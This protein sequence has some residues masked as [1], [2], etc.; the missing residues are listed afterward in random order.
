M[1]NIKFSLIYNRK[2]Q[3]NQDGSALIQIK[4]YLKGKN[5]YF[6]SEIYV[7]PHQWD[8]RNKK[9]KR[10]P[11]QYP[12]N[13]K[14]FE[15]LE[16]LENRAMTLHSKQDGFINLEQLKDD[17]HS[18]EYNSFTQFF[19]IEMRNEQ[20]SK[21]TRKTYVTTFR[22]IK[23]FRKSIHFKELNFELI[24]TFDA[25]L[26]ESGL[27]QNTIAK[28][29]K[30]VK[31]FINLAIKMNLMDYSDNPYRKF[32]IKKE[33]TER[34]FL[35]ESEIQSLEALNLES[36]SSE[37]EPIRDMFLFSCYTGLRY[38][39]VSRLCLNHLTKNSKGYLL[40]MT[41]QKTGKKIELPLYALFRVKDE[42]QSKPERIIEKQIEYHELIL[43]KN[44]TFNEIPIFGEY[45]GQYVNRTLKTIGR[46]AGLKNKSL[47]THTARH[48]FGTAM[49]IKVKLPILQKL[50]QHSSLRETQIYLHMSGQVIE[51]EL[52]KVNW[53]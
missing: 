30:N 10:H 20:V 35:S 21:A 19:M 6:S 3:L 14:I 41:A 31:K 27:K 33:A 46:M 45:S 18:N 51:N 36:E 1:K 16:E 34:A 5:K 47:S 53:G 43:G 24:R 44:A 8:E 52:E 15:Q 26:K 48:S 17:Q 13:K 11:N 38:S 23:Q 22:K 2:N 9:I 39:D 40:R 28:H 42:H 4:A 49:A 32:V 7:K 12:L 37:L 25:F 29:H 50:M